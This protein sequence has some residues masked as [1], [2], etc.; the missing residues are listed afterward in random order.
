[1]YI[2]RP[3]LEPQ[4]RFIPCFGTKRLFIKRKK[5]SKTFLE[6]KKNNKKLDNQTLGLT[7]FSAKKS[8]AEKVSVYFMNEG[9]VVERRKESINPWLSD[10][11]E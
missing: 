5:K 11:T 7:F 10:N 6:K 4:D 1:M 2:A 3:D 9:H 8:S